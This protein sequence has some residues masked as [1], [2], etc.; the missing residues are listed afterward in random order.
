[1]NKTVKIRIHSGGGWEGHVV[2]VGINPNNPK[3]R[4]TTNYIDDIR[5]FC[6]L[7]GLNMDK[8]FEEHLR[9]HLVFRNDLG[10]YIIH[11]Q[12]INESAP[13]TSAFDFLREHFPKEYKLQAD[14]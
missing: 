8:Q 9:C 12:Y 10:L 13:I 14:D 7:K 6:I 2:F 4:I 11:P 5:E 3:D 1:M